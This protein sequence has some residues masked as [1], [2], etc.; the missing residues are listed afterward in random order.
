MAFETRLTANGK[1]PEPKLARTSSLSYKKAN[2][3]PHL[4]HATSRS[5]QVILV[6]CLNP[7]KLLLY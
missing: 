4:I 2:I 1:P 7:V 5:V 3:H 6:L